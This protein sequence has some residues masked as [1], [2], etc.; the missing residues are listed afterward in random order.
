MPPQ[1]TRTILLLY[2]TRCGL[3]TPK[4]HRSVYAVLEVD[5]DG[6][7][8]FNVSI[9]R[10]WLRH[11]QPA[12][13]GLHQTFEVSQTSKV[14]Q[15]NGPDP[16]GP[17]ALPGEPERAATLGEQVAKKRGMSY[18]V[19]AGGGVCKRLFRQE[20]IFLSDIII[21]C[22]SV[23]YKSFPGKHNRK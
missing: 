9:S 3:G 8:H 16:N 6:P 13:E 2:I 7:I 15:Q 1:Q 18:I 19:W 22:M 11:N 14:Y 5:W 20:A 23:F 4:P 10:P 12:R 17:P 21:T